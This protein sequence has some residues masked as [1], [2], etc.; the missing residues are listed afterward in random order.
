MTPTK[1]GTP[2][3]LRYDRRRPSNRGSPPKRSRRHAANSNRLVNVF[4]QIHIERVFQKPRITVIVFG[5]DNDQPVAAIDHRRERWV[6]HLLACIIQFHW[7]FAHIDQFRLHIRALLCLLKNETCDVL[8]LP[9]LTRSSENNG[10]KKRALHLS[11][12]RYPKLKNCRWPDSNRHGPFT[13]QR[14]LS[15]L[16]LPFRHIGAVRRI[17]SLFCNPRK[18]ISHLRIYIWSSRKRFVVHVM[19][20]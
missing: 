1:I 16:R 6:L 12:F 20:S 18:R 10:N 7:E 8:A 19:K 3:Q 9:S 13:A 11:A 5:R 15:P 14:I 17:L 2:P 4:F